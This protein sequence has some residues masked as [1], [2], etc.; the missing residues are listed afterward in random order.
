MVIPILITL[1]LDDLLPGDLEAAA[2]HPRLVPLVPP[3]QAVLT[4]VLALVATIGAILE[5]EKYN[6]FLKLLLRM[7][8]L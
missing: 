4:H 7:C 3:D 6:A 2:H 8:N 1:G 5:A